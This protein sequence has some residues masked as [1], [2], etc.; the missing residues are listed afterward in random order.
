MGDSRSGQMRLTVACVN[1][2]R[3]RPFQTDSVSVFH[4][5]RGSVLRSCP[6]QTDSD[7]FRPT[8]GPRGQRLPNQQVEGSIPSWRASASRAPVAGCVPRGDSRASKSSSTLRNA[9]HQR[10]N[11][12]RHISIPVAEMGPFSGRAFLASSGGFRSTCAADILQKREVPAGTS[13]RAADY[14]ARG[15]GAKF[16]PGS[17]AQ[18]AMVRAMVTATDRGSDPGRRRQA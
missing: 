15:N 14:V 3:L 1:S 9:Q 5:G 2:V 10:G 6:T 4:A 12:A 11:W 8:R 13:G 7:R 17:V 16:G 18:W